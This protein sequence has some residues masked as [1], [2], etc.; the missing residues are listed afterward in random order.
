MPQTSP[1]RLASHHHEQPDDYVSTCLPLLLLR[2]LLCATTMCS[3]L[4]VPRSGGCSRSCGEK[5]PIQTFFFLNTPTNVARR[6]GGN[7]GPVVQQMIRGMYEK[8]QSE[9]DYGVAE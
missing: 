8:E 6:V 4:F 5:K 1:Q 9:Y 7:K 3:L 2:L